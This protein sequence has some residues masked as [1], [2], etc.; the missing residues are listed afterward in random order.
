LN[1]YLGILRRLAGAFGVTA[2]VLALVL[3]VVLGLDKLLRPRQTDASSAEIPPLA[4]VDSIRVSIRDL[5]KQR[6]IPPVPEFTIPPPYMPLFV[7]LFSESNPNRHQRFSTEVA[8]GDVTFVAKS[9]RTIHATFYDEGKNPLCFSVAGVQYVRV[10][11]K[12]KPIA[13]S[14]TSVSYSDEA[15]LLYYVIRA[16]HAELTSGEKANDLQ[17]SLEDLERSIGAR[18]PKLY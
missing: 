3:G 9:G 14:R 11:D 16:I 13:T 17:E 12:Y 8:V 5:R 10:R 18:P 1:S 6:E 7:R 15:W 2:L 4:E